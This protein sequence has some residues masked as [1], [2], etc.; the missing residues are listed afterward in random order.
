MVINQSLEMFFTEG[1]KLR[2]DNLILKNM[3]VDHKY[4]EDYESFKSLK[5]YILQ[6]I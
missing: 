2:Q 1:M 6:Y 4:S 5:V 3:P